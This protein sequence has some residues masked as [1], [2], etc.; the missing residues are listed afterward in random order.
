MNKKTIITSLL[1]LAILPVSA[2]KL[3]ATKTTIDVGKTGFQ[4]PVTAVFEFKNKS[5]RRLTIESVQPDCSCTTID[6]PKKVIGMGE[7]FEIKMTYDAKMLGHFDK[8]AAIISNGTKKPVYIRMKGI[9]SESYQDFSGDYPIEMG[10][11]R[12]DKNELEFDNVNKGEMPIAQIHVYNNGTGLMR[13]NL[14]HLPSYLSAT[15]APEEIRPGRS[16]TIS[17]TLNSNKVSD[18]GLTQESIYLAA[19]PGDKATKDNLIGV[20]T[21]LLPSFTK[22]TATQKLYAPKMYLSKDQVDIV[23]DGKSKKKDEIQISNTGRTPLTISSLQMFTEGLQ[24]SLGKST[25]QTGESTKLKIT[26]QRDVLKN[27]R[28]KPRIL[29][30]TN[31]PDQS[32]VVITINVK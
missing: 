22:M 17:V 14:M 28:T 19:N 21:V 2:Q 9:V 32:K 30:I 11:M 16:A 31:D 25:L 10:N 23:F 13:P 24:I 8:Q 1:M 12:I 4:Q 5:I 20:S 7:K 27:V 3:I 29:M 6:Y 26:A 18:Y 15:V